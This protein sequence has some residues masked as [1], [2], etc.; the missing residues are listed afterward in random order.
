[1]R[2]DHF[3]RVVN[4]LAE[5][6]DQLDTVSVELLRFDRRFVAAEGDVVLSASAARE[7]RRLIALSRQVLRVVPVEASS[8]HAE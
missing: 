2:V 8:S 5:F 7:L 1:M 3:N 6:S 4:A